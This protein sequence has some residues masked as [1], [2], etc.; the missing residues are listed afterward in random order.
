MFKVKVVLPA[1]L[2]AINVYDCCAVG[3]VGVPSMTPVDI[4]RVNPLG[5]AGLTL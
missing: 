5:N 3:A 4:S 1:A 2:L